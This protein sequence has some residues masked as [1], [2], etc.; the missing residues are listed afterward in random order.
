MFVK[1]NCL[2]KG[3]TLIEIMIVIVLIGIIMMISMGAFMS[4]RKSARDGKR[5]ADLEAVRS[6]VEMYRSDLN[7]YPAN[8]EVIFG[9]QLTDPVDVNKVYMHLVP[10]D[11]LNSSGRTYTYVRTL[12]SYL[13][14]AYLENPPPSLSVG[15]SARAAD[16]GSGKCGSVASPL[17]CNYITCNP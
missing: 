4:S 5:K 1:K 7:S 3:F 15:C 10:Q 8:A 14:C 2:L 16:C 9:G 12:N 17:D 6:A 11:P 13:L